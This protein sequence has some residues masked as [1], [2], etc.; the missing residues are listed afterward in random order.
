M[1]YIPVEGR[2][3]LGRDPQSGAIVA[4]DKDKYNQTLDRKLLLRRIEQLEEKVKSQDE[5]ILLI[6]QKLCE[7]MKSLENNKE[8]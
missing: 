5:R 1:S 2:P 4:V 3:D 6:T 7:V 8:E